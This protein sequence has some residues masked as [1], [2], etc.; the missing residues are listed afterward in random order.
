VKL[1]QIDS[2]ITGDQSV[3]RQLTGRIVDSLRQAVPEITTTYRDLAK[4]PLPHHAVSHE[5]ERDRAAAAA[6]LEEF[7]DADIV[8]IGA[9]MYNFGISSQLKGWIDSVLVAGKTFQ[10]TENGVQGLTG[11]KRVIVASSRGGV[12]SDG[13]MASVDHQETYLRDVLRF[14]GITDVQF[15]RAEGLG[16]GADARRQAIETAFGQ[17]D[18]L[19]GRSEAVAA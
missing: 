13:P 7:L 17:A 12:Y 3:S 1:L 11:G 9:P 2:S 15:V 14:I 19:S 8:V 5:A 16:M 18:A 4:D 10:Y 6:S